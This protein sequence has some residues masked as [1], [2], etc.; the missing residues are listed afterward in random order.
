MDKK[1][2]RISLIDSRNKISYESRR[3]ASVLICDNLVSSD[4]YKNS[5]NI[6]CFHSYSSEI[7]TIRFINKCID[8]LKSIYLPK[9]FKDYILF[10]KVDSLDDLVK[11]YKGIPEPVGT[12]ER[13]NP[14]TVFKSMLVMPGVGFD[15]K[16]HRLGYGGGYYDRFL[17]KYPEFIRRSVAIGY[18]CQMVD[19]LPVDEYDIKPG[20]IILV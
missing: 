15:E 3:E 6:L 20:K 5:E 4:I 1:S 10:Y 17:D 19:S 7:D 18:K 11:G 12:S 14:E 9:T 16:G 8:D 2:Y 13:W